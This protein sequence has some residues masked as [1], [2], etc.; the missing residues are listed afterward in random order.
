MLIGLSD[1]EV[2]SQL[3]QF[4]DDSKDD[5]E[6]FTEVETDD[7]SALELKLLSRAGAEPAVY[8][9]PLVNGQGEVIQFLISLVI[10]LN[11]SFESLHYYRLRKTGLWKL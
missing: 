11:I 9:W 7:E 2:N 3:E 6:I 5:G 10:L 8:P 4:I 1:Y